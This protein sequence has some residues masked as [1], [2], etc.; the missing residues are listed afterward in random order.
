M[1]DVVDTDCTISN[2]SIGFHNR[3][4]FSCNEYV[5]ESN[6]LKL[7][8]DFKQYNKSSSEHQTYGNA[9]EEVEES[10]EVHDNEKTNTNA[11]KITF[12][13]P[14]AEPNGW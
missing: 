5:Q 4:L 13:K 6:N 7:Q 12:D 14:P 3:N 10:V 8:C 11:Q 9:S 1:T 2:E